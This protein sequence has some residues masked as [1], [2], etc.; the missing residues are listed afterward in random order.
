MMI[1]LFHALQSQH[2]QSSRPKTYKKSLAGEL[3]TTSRETVEMEMTSMVLSAPSGLP[4]GLPIGS[5][6]HSQKSPFPSLSSPSPL[7]LFGE[8]K[9]DGTKVICIC[10]KSFGWR[11]KN[12]KYRF[13][14]CF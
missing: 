10:A 6:S 14:L 3:P 11:V 4:S 5:P 8:Y 2:G 7:S 12:S 1:K 9:Q 13:C